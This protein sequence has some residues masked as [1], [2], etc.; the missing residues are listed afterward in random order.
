MTFLSRYIHILV[1]LA[2]LGLPGFVQAN[3][4]SPCPP[5]EQ[6][7]R[8]SPADSFY[9]GKAYDEGSCNFPVDKEKAHDWYKKSA[10]AGNIMALHALGESYFTGNGADPDYP[11]AKKWFLKAAER[12]HGLSQLRLGFLY[13]EKHFSGL[14]PDYGEAEKWFLKAAEQNTED[15]AFRLGNFYN[16]YKIP[17]DYA[18]GYIWIKKAAE[19][20]HRVAMFDLSRILMDGRGGEKDIAAGLDWMEQAAELDLLQAQIRLSNI[21]ADGKETAQN[22]SKSLKWALRIAQK[23]TAAALY[24]NRVADIFFDG[25]EGMPKNYPVARIFY[26]RA[27]AKGDTHAKERLEQIYREGLGVS[28]DTDKAATYRQE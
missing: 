9:R 2:L 25:R 12:G 17:P 19:N 27:A 21:Y 7:G 8:E 11:E 1:L 28:I 16:N 18:Q 13:A 23:E 15:A 5:H 22:S 10:E 14:S 4:T 3:D 26:E 24:L 6:T 20:G